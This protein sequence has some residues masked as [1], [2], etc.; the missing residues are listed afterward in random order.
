MEFLFENPFILV[1]L[2]GLISSLFG[3]K[4]DQEDQKKQPAN[5]RRPQ[6]QPRQPYDRKGTGQRQGRPQ[7]RL[8]PASAKQIPA[9]VKMEDYQP[10]ALTEL[11]EKYEEKKRAEAALKR[12][13]QTRPGRL[14]RSGA[15]PIRANEI[16]LDLKPEGER[17][18]EGLAWSQILGEPRSKQPHRTMRRR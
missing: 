6:Q 17:L 14:D 11:Q 18:I 12:A 1:V 4:G 2:I 15:D 16:G 10:E 3:K 8:E 5:P 13:G 7:P 9:K